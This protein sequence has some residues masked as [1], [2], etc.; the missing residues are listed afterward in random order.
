MALFHKGGVGAGPCFSWYG[1]ICVT[2]FCDE[3]RFGVRVG[4]DGDY[5]RSWVYLPAVNIL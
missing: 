5:D 1:V 2:I 3:F 4:V